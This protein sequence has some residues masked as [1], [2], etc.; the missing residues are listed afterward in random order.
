MQC[1]KYSAKFSSF[2]NFLFANKNTK[3]AVDFLKQNLMAVSF[4]DQP[5]ELARPSTMKRS[6]FWNPS[7]RDIYNVLVHGSLSLTLFFW[8]CYV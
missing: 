8:L 6:N 1:P 5:L 3:N 4:E 7:L 2:N